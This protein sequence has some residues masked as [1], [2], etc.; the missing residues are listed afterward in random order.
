MTTIYTGPIGSPRPETPVLN[1]DNTLTREYQDY[2][3]AVLRRTG[4]TNNG[5]LSNHQ[6][7]EG[8]NTLEYLANNTFT[9]NGTIDINSIFK[10]AGITVTATA[11]ELNLLHG[12]IAPTNG[13]IL[14]GSGSAGAFRTATLSISEGLSTTLG[15]GTLSVTANIATTSLK[16]V[17]Q[18][19]PAF[20]TVTAGNVSVSANSSIT[21]ANVTVTNTLAINGI[22]KI[23][24][25]TVNATAAELNL[26]S[27]AVSPTNGQ[28]LV[29]STSAG[30]FRTATLSISDG[31]SITLGNGALA[32]TANIASTSV[33]GVAQ[34]DPAFFIVNSGNVTLSSNSS[35]TC[36]NLTVT[37]NLDING[38]W[39]ISGSTVTSTAAEI[40]LLKGAVSPTNGQILVGSGS[41]AAFRTTTLSIS[42][43]LSSVLGNGTLSVTANVASTSIKGV[44]QFDPA[45][46]TV[47]AGNVSLSST[48]SSTFA[49]VT[50]TDTLAINGIW[51]ISGTTVTSTAAELNFLHGAGSPT[52]GQILVGS[53]SAGAFRT[54]TLGI[55][56]GLSTSLGNG[57]LSVSA[58]IATTLLK[59]V[60]LFN[61]AYF[62]VSSGNVSFSNTSSP[63]FANLTVTSQALVGSGVFD[64][65]S[66]L[67]IRPS[68]SSSFDRG[69]YVIG[70]LNG[71]ST[72][73]QSAIQVGTT[74]TLTQNVTTV[75]AY[76]AYSTTFNAGA[77]NTLTN[78]V[79]YFAS[80]NFLPNNGN[81]TNSIGFYYDG[82]F[83]T[84]PGNVS[85]GYGALIKLPVSGS[86][87]AVGIYTDSLCVGV[88][89]LTTAP[90]ANGI[91]T[92]ALT[93]PTGASNGYLLKGDGSGNSS[94]I[95]LST[96]AV[97]NLSGTTN[98]I[99]VGSAVGSSVL[100][101]DNGISL[102]SLVGTAPPTGGLLIPGRSIFRSGGSTVSTAFFQI[103][104]V[105]S[106]ISGT[107]HAL[108]FGAGTLTATA[109]SDTINLMSMVN[110]AI[111]RAG[112]TGLNFRI[113]NIDGSNFT[114]SGGGSSSNAYG[115]KAAGFVS[116][117]T[118]QYTGY[119]TAST[120]GTINTAL[121]TDNL[122]V[123]TSYITS[124]P[125]AN[126]AIIQGNVGIGVSSLSSSSNLQISDSDSLTRVFIENTSANG[127]ASLLMN[128]SGTSGF[129]QIQNSNGDLYITNDGVKDI[130]FRANSSTQNLRINNNGGLSV[131]QSFAM[132]ASPA[133][134]AIVQG[135]MGI[136]T[137]SVS[138]IGAINFQVGD[139]AGG[140]AYLN[141]NS[142]TANQSG[143]KWLNAGSAKWT[144]ARVA[145][146]NDLLLFAD[147]SG[148]NS[149]FME[150][151]TGN[152]AI[153]ASS[154][155]DS[156]PLSVTTSVSRGF[157]VF[158]G[159]AGVDLD[160]Q[161]YRNAGTVSRWQ[162]YLPSSDTSF[163]I[164]SHTAPA[165]DR[166]YISPNGSGQLDAYLNATGT[167]QFCNLHFKNSVREQA[168]ELDAS[169]NLLFYD[170]TGAFQTL[171][172]TTSGN[173]CIG[174][175]T[176]TAKLTVEGSIWG[177]IDNTFFG[178]D[179][180]GPRVGFTKKSG[181]L[182]K[183]T[184]GSAS[185]FAIARSN[186]TD[187][188]S[189]H[190]FTDEFIIDSAGNFGLGAAT[191]AGWFISVTGTTSTFYVSR[192]TTTITATDGANQVG[193][194]YANSYFPTNG[195]TSSR[196]L[197]INSDF[198]APTGKTIT[199]VFGTYS[200]ITFNSNAGTLANV[201]DHY[202]DA[203]AGL[204]GT[205]TNHY[206]LKVTA[207]SAGTNKYTAVFD[208]GVG[209]GVD[210]TGATDALQVAGHSA[211]TTA[212]K[213]F[214]VKQ[215]ANSCM[216]TGAVM[217]AGAV[218]VNTTAV[219]TGDLVVTERTAVGGT[220]GLGQPT[221]TIVNGTSF[222]LTSSNV[223]DTST[224]SWII[225]KAA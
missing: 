147:G 136:G 89:N 135:D 213:T 43:G 210:N 16:G 99:V 127:Q 26:L 91:R 159:T 98:Q 94:W 70:G 156:Y 17:A 110:T 59:G 198:S 166:F 83:S 114:P 172:V 104:P 1:N 35:I 124:A 37:S 169:G 31:L 39:K 143:V 171:E 9:I 92:A 149:I 137:S 123:G 224:Y 199:S 170:I 174:A 87:F 96:I 63:T 50:V 168:I 145:G 141:I 202:I 163:R 128:T 30:A 2:F 52:D 76:S 144:L 121:Y 184:H 194:W 111:A 74:F 140:A 86:A 51:K 112:F 220:I 162:M 21:Y 61:A 214:K 118:N 3:L 57:T 117:A 155:P 103:T 167:A 54:T 60:A 27:G 161:L 44:A 173:V 101:L 73:R 79:S 178:L 11:A 42:E 64:S 186:G 164:Y 18:F 195:S 158:S 88:N 218:T 119:F 223:L 33:R 69:L 41:A 34:F 153:R 20:F 25:T 221:V 126:G 97:T 13:Q 47:T 116:H 106:V 190:T 29:G 80:P 10:I 12:A 32:L 216:G 148:L 95:D 133:N 185:S 55:S 14:V 130:I 58:N 192:W 68:T 131:G 215:G 225:F 207:P 65:L 53:T 182:M 108:F 105:S 84:S 81:V 146:A 181:N 206:A 209:I 177:T 93:M 175:S 212:G 72:A 62:T 23:G 150:Q 8:S 4:G 138:S 176:P 211:V 132:G 90:P 160:V 188:G 67:T 36:A 19:D 200:G 75:S 193:Q 71:T 125:P 203:T 85:N 15:N 28:I 201:Y 180:S 113:L 187:I 45:F 46:F 154:I 208:V 219:A 165:G 189:S 151:S 22:W 24:G 122:V 179:T 5:I 120:G 115:I 6:F 48:S 191:T 78:A 204:N 7:T 102:G 107:L 134:G 157:L 222:T 56:D 183:M 197:F 205:I 142:A 217:V 129:S 40:N 49:N 77:G 152:V 109:N 196:E 66:N 139:T 82:G 38:S 100:S